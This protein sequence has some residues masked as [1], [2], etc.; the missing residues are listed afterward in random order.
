MQSR[1]HVAGDN[2]TNSQAQRRPPPSSPAEIAA[3]HG[4]RNAAIVAAYVTGAYSYRQIAEHF[5]IHLA[6]V[7]CIVREAIIQCEN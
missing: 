7:G 2:L 6:T 3:H 4:E 5:G 1:A